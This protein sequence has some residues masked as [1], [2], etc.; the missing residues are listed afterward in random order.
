MPISTE[1]IGFDQLP[2]AVATLL[3][4]VRC[5]KEMISDREKTGKEASDITWLSLSE[6]CEYLPDHP[7]KP[8]VYGWVC[9]RQI[10]YYKV[11]KRLS[12]RKS[13]IDEWIIRT[14]RKTAEQLRKEGLESHGYKKGGRL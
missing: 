12:F 5:L 13:E 7:S 3:D 9:N 11:G 4:E 6:L 10:P 2:S 1:N 8:T 14:G